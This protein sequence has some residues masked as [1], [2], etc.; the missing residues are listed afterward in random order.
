MPAPERR[1]RTGS[2]FRKGD[3]AMPRS[4][5]WVRRLTA[6][7]VGLA[8]AVAAQAGTTGKLTGRVVDEKKQPLAGVNIR[9]EGQ[10][11]GAI[12][13]DNGE[14]FII[15][16]PGGRHTVRMN[17][18][19]YAAFVAQNV[20]VTPDFTTPLDATLR[21]EAVQMNE[22]V[23][24]AERPLLQ[25]DATGTTRFI[26]ASEI[27]RLPTRGYRDAAAQQTGVV[28]F[29]RQIDTESQNGNTLIIRGGRPNETA[30]F[31]DGFSQQDPLTGT[32]STSISN[33]SIEEV[34]VLTGGFNSEYGRIM[35]GAVNV[36]T[37]EGSSKY[38]GSVETVTDMGVGS[39]LGAHPV[40][41]NVYDVSFGGP[42]WPNLESVRFHVSGERRWQRDRNP[43]PLSSFM[44][45]QLEAAGLDSDFK[46][47]NS[48]GG[49]TFQGKL[50]WQ[51]SDQ[52]SLKLGG[53]GSEDEW[54]E[55]A[56]TYLFNLDHSPRYYDRNLSYNATFN[57]VLSP[58]TFYTVGG[59]YFETLRK[60]GD[61]VH[62]DN[63]EDYYRVSNPRFNSDAPMFWNPGHVFDDYL[64]RKSSY[65]GA[66]ASLTS[67][68]NRHNQVKLGG[69]LQLHTL[70]YFNHF[71]PT[72]LGGASPNFNDWDGYGYD[73]VSRNGDIFLEE[74]DSGDDGAKH[75]KTWSV[76]L[77]DKFE[78][79][80]VIVNAGMRVDH[81]NVD[82]P[83][84][85]R[86]SSPLEDGPFPD[87]LDA[88]DL[89]QNKTYMRVSPR[90]GIAFPVDERTQLRFNYGQ[91]YQQP[92]LQDLYVSYRFMEYYLNQASYFVPFGN[93]NLKPERTTAYEV[94]IARQIGDR[95]RV[96]VTA[97]YKDVKDLVE[98]TTIRARPQGF[99][100]FRNR[101]FA[102][103]KGVDI[104]F[105]MRRTRNVAASVNYSL[106]YAQGTGSVSR[107]QGIIAWTQ[108]ETPKQTSP[109]DFDQRHKISI[110]LDFSLDRGQ[111]PSWGGWRPFEDLGIN[112]LY[113]VGSGTPYTPTT[114]FNEVTLASVSSLVSGPL[115]SRYGPWQQTID[116]KAARAF[117]MGPTKLNAFLWVLNLLDTKNSINVY[118]SSGSST[119]TSWLNTEDGQ[120]Y[121]TSAATAGLDGLGLYR[122][123][124]NDPGLFANPRLVRF[125]IGASF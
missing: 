58:K 125:G 15:G 99:T 55:Y 84:L 31:V 42:L 69:D 88:A 24:S 61:G 50:S 66:Q 19:G 95:M 5:P 8:L 7:A 32:S 109:L 4:L 59:N 40:D 73:L 93:P 53:L 101:D 113:N 35:S 22:V 43:T 20:E 107:T 92:N 30:Y 79:E 91:F 72:Q 114:V 9:I 57:H 56:H 2:P 39:A 110:N 117:Q 44:V 12:T 47:N 16:I 90:L 64:Q 81:I 52:I 87:S 48:L 11:L 123:A 105:A 54:R 96:D 106:A 104:G 119:T 86:D 74:S 46:P 78:R 100:S 6:I 124:E 112:V 34:V 62:F 26:S 97:Y 14:Y 37:R 65:Y 75:P 77:Q 118:S 71:F 76:F 121:L 122:L 49:F 38:T 21:S 98:V 115:N 70:R 29:R 10:R 116:V 1:A 33:N 102:T 3:S 63:L 80:G 68:V 67:Q 94:G 82:T 89:T 23:V 83:A 111:G 45:R 108:D 85:L 27:E 60:R 36:L 17:L 13:D 120:R 41:F 51:L 25:R 103:I 28:N 18:I